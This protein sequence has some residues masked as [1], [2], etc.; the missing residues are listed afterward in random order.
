[1]VPLVRHSKENAL[2]RDE[3]EELVEACDKSLFPRQNRFL[4]LVM[5][6]LGLRAAEVAHM[7]SLG[8]SSQ[9]DDK[10]SGARAL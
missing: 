6:R 10:D 3:F 8:W 5:G 2:E 4:V 7:K 9:K 1:M